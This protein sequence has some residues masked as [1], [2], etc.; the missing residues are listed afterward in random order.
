LRR[1]CQ[2][3]IFHDGQRVWILHP[4]TYMSNVNYQD[5]VEN[6]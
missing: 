5:K 2:S 3:E 1:Q 6:N 4:H